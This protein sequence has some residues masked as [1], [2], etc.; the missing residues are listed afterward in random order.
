MRERDVGTIGENEF[1]SWCQPEGFRAQK[2]AM[3][4]LGWDYLLEREPMRSADQPLDGQNE[5][6]KFL[7]QVKSTDRVGK[8]PRIK[9]SA[10]KHL[11][12]ADLPAAIAVLEFGNERRSPIR[13]LIVP[14][15]DMIINK[16]LRRVRQEEARGNRELHKVTVLVPL[17][18]AVKVGNE[19][20]GLSDALDAMLGGPFSA[21]IRNKIQQRQ[22]CG[23]E[24]GSVVGKFF[25]HGDDAREKIHSLFLGRRREIDV[26]NLSVERRRFGIPLKNDTDF[27]RN[28][29]LEFQAH[30]LMSGSIE[31]EDLDDG[32]WT[33]FSVGVYVVP[34]TLNNERN[35]PIRLANKYFELILDFDKEWAGITF[36]YDGSQ[37]AD[38][39][40]AVTIIEVGAI[41][42][43]ARKKIKIEMG[44][45]K[46][47]LPAVDGELGP[48]HNW[49]P[50]AFMLRRMSSAIERRAR[51]DKLRVLLSTFYEWVEKHQDLLALGST[52][53]VN[54]FL[55]RWDG[56]A[57]MDDHDTLLAPLTLE[58]VG[59]QYTVLIEVPIETLGRDELEI[60]IVGGQPRVVDDIARSVGS[61]TTDFVDRAIEISKRQRKAAGP[62]LVVSAFEKWT[63]GSA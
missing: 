49:I 19:G 34:P 46:L 55:P 51:S 4:R 11:V 9:L 42:A 47:E 35:G 48:F 16:T 21:Y 36:N 44:A 54:L 15:D 27:F 50:V 58:L 12:D 59:A 31:L 25:V 30:P 60:K 10:L 14:V 5:L 40:D 6:A 22:I 1:L 57:V 20:E 38:L 2:S 41:L 7:V 62:A 32:Q 18:R 37:S 53:G 17:D 23:F 29:I 28:A 61:S 43:R 56:D 52:R 3:D 26:I 33:R 63:I 24:D 8:G 39:D 45:A 13:S